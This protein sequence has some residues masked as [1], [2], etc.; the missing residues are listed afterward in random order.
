MLNFNINKAIPTKYG[1]KRLKDFKDIVIYEVTG[2]EPVASSISTKKCS[3]DGTVFQGITRNERNLIIKGYITRNV[4]ENRHYLY[5]LFESSNKAVE[6]IFDDIYYIDGYIEN[7]EMNNY[8]EKTTFQVSV[9]CPNPFFYTEE[10]IITGITTDDGTNY[11][12][13][14][15]GNDWEVEIAFLGSS[16]YIEFTLNGGIDNY[17]IDYTFKSGDVL[18]VDYKDRTVTVNGK[19]IYGYKKWSRWKSLSWNGN[20]RFK[21]SCV[22]DAYLKYKNK[23]NG[24]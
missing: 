20:F 5:D 24:I 17:R 10:Q 16:N 7:I 23:Y 22:C 21:A 15:N 19:N 3:K 9:I 1:D 13:E 8:Q 2:L 18:Y 12:C 11:T 14:R 4:K 6:F